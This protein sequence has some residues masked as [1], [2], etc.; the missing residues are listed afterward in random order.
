MMKDT[1]RTECFNIVS[2]WKDEKTNKKYIYESETIWAKPSVSKGSYVDVY[3]DKN[4]FKKYYIDIE[5]IKCGI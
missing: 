3:I 5:E 4:N 1:G 2:E